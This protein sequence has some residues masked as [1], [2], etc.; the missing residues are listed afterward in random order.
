MIK[1]TKEACCCQKTENLTTKSKC[2]EHKN[3]GSSGSGIYFFGFIGAAF[4]FIPQAT[5]FWL[6]VVALLKA[7]VW[8]AFLIYGL[9]NF[10]QI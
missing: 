8:P 10:L 2:Q 1:K 9:L 6:G 7:F 5:S 4:Y 3:Y